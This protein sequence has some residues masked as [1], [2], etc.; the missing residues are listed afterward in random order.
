MWLLRPSVCKTP[1]VVGLSK[2]GRWGRWNQVLSTG[3]SRP[4]SPIWT[5]M[6]DGIRSYWLWWRHHNKQKKQSFDAILR[7]A[8]RNTKETHDIP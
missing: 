7:H 1:S 3:E 4:V 5:I 6:P 8:E 2:I